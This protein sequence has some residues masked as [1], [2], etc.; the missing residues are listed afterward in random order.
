MSWNYRIVK[1]AHGPGFGLHEVH[2]D[3]NGEAIR[4]T[5]NP[6]GFVGDTEKE[7]RDS[8]VLAVRDARGRP[9]FEEPQDWN[10]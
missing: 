4:M 8:F 6:A 2:Y 5:E 9:V 3:E 1:Y 7:L 10:T